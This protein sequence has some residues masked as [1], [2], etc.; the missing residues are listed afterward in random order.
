M[1]GLSL[2]LVKPKFFCNKDGSFQACT[3][4]EYCAITNADDRSINLE[5]SRKTITSDFELYCDRHY[6]IGWLG[7]LLFLGNLFSFFEKSLNQNRHI[8]GRILFPLSGQLERK[9]NGNLHFCSSGRR[10]NGCHRSC[11]S[12]RNCYGLHCFGR[13]SFWR[14]RNYCDS[15]HCRVIR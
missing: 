10:R 5:D 7:S 14:V 13:N 11:E 6:I 8:F 12:H 4:D 3:E 9:K 1:M 2:L 15:L